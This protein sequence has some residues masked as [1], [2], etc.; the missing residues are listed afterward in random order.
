MDHDRGN[1]LS[2]GT[3][4]EQRLLKIKVTESWAT[5][6]K[7][8][9]YRTGY[10]PGSGRPVSTM[11]Q[12]STGWGM[13][14]HRVASG[15]RRPPTCWDHL[16]PIAPAGVVQAETEE[17]RRKEVMLSAATGHI[18]P[19]VIHQSSCMACQPWGSRGTGSRWCQE[20]PVTSTQGA[21]GPHIIG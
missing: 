1:H 16:L 19:D 14:H 12:Q 8:Q 9:E 15:S 20:L 11:D 6:A 3:V 18:Q 13:E 21:K 5:V 2:P 7:E 17:A 10:S 4:N